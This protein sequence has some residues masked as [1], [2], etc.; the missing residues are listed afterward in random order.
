M[1]QRTE[2]ALKALR[3]GNFRELCGAVRNQYQ[4]WLQVAGALF[5]TRAGRDGGTVA[6]ATRPRSATERR[7]GLRDG[8]PEAGPSGL[9]TAE[10]PRTLSS[11]ERPGRTFKRVLQRERPNPSP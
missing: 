7:G 2:F 9:G 10:D 3:T 5:T 11:P 6:A 4:D 1:E 8:G